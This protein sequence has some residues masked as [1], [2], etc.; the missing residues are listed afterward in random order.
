MIADTS[1]S[2]LLQQISP[3]RLAQLSGKSIWVVGGGSGYGKAASLVLLAA[4]CDVFISGRNYEKLQKTQKMAAL[5]KLDVTNMHL[6]PTDINNSKRIEKTVKAIASYSDSLDGLVLTAAVPQ[7]NSTNTPLLDYSFEQWQTM[8]NTNLSSA[9]LLVQSA[10]PL[11]VATESSRIVCFTSRA[12]W[13]DTLGFGS[14]NISKCALN[15]Y[16]ASMAQELTYK[17]PD[18]D[19]QINGIE[20]GE[21]FTEMNQGSPT[22]PL[23]I[24]KVLLHLLTMPK[25]QPSGRFFDRE[26]NLIN[27]NSVGS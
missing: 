12:G 23:A 26:L 1:I 27:F 15:S 3:D 24:S 11:L 21:A 4:G 10:L 8:L 19:I 22:S 13:A 18:K 6:I 7:N 2:Q 16:I 20:P 5:M 17:Y 14:Y 25:N 9:F